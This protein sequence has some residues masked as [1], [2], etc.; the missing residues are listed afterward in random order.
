PDLSPDGQRLRVICGGEPVFFLEAG[1]IAKV[2]QRG[3]K[4]DRVPDL[5]ADGKA[6]LQQDTSGVELALNQLEQA[7]VVQFVTH[8]THVVDRLV[9]L[10]ALHVA[11]VGL[12]VLAE[13]QRQVAEVVQG[14][15]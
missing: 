11:G 12:G 10:H 8:A 14:Q 13:F 3:G 1:D 2:A 6:P 4:R 15:G 9:Q 5:P 7:Q